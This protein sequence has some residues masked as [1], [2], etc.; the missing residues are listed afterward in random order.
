VKSRVNTH[1][2]VVDRV[3]FKIFLEPVVAGDGAG[4]ACTRVFASW[5]A[6]GTNRFAGDVLF[7]ARV[8]DATIS[9]AEENGQRNDGR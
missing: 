4:F 8:L 1:P 9:V 6:N 7:M 2:E 5:L 3:S